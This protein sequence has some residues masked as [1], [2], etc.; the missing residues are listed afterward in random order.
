MSAN[1]TE[2]I[3]EELVYQWNGQKTP[4]ILDKIKYDG[5]KYEPETV[6][7]VFVKAEG[8]YQF[9]AADQDN[10]VIKSAWI[11]TDKDILDNTADNDWRWYHANDSGNI[12]LNTV[13]S[14]SP[15]SA[16]EKVP[17]NAYGVYCEEGDAVRELAHTSAEY[18]TKLSDSAYQ[19]FISTHWDKTFGQKKPYEDA[20]IWEYAGTSNGLPY[21]V[22]YSYDK[23]GNKEKNVFRTDYDKTSGQGTAK[24]FN[25][26]GVYVALREVVSTLPG[27]DAVAF[28]TTV[29]TGDVDIAEEDYNAWIAMNYTNG[30]YYEWEDDEYYY[31]ATATLV[32]QEGAYRF[33]EDGRKVYIT[34]YDHLSHKSGAGTV[35]NEGEEYTWDDGTYYYVMRPVFVKYITIGSYVEGAVFED[36][37]L[38]AS[39]EDSITLDCHLDRKADHFALGCGMKQGDYITSDD[40]HI[41]ETFLMTDK[42]ILEGLGIDTSKNPSVLVKNICKYHTEQDVKDGILS[43]YEAQEE[44]S[45]VDWG[46]GYVKELDHQGNPIK[47]SDG[48]TYKYIGCKTDGVE[49]TQQYACGIATMTLI[50][51]ATSCNKYSQF[52]VEL[53]VSDSKG[54]VVTATPIACNKHMYSLSDELIGTKDP[55]TGG[56][57]RGPALIVLYGPYLESSATDSSIK[58]TPE[59]YKVSCGITK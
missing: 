37:L 49:K 7:G 16:S 28:S 8:G 30:K 29:S 5:D 2:E 24:F 33:D 18:I 46:V 56:E 25:E 10:E 51:Y 11:F 55:E 45:I 50:G 21:A 40:D 23:D 47:H 43:Q 35:Y 13:V 19:D 26:N 17:V 48:E 34:T 32:E 1:K 14:C 54:D 41:E 15:S 38:G 12:D 36:K 6:N 57:Y 27:Q 20:L 44:G 4:K 22:Q 31:R 59:K 52:D 58:A 3:N 9:V 39:G 42:E 53:G